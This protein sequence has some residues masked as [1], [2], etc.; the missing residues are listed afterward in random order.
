[1]R[2]PSSLLPLMFSFLFAVACADTATAPEGENSVVTVEDEPNDSSETG[3]DEDRTPTTREGSPCDTEG[4][5]DCDLD[6]A[7]VC[8]GGIWTFLES[9][10]GE[11]TCSMT[12]GTCEEKICDRGERRC[13]DRETIE[14][15]KPDQT[16][17][18]DP[19]AYPGTQICTDGACVGAQCFPGVMFLVDRSTSM[20]EH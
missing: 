15:C 12:T 8:Q 17:W 5:R 9:C 6:D 11:W 13:V 20:Q 19:Q 4:E 10:E 18:L 2:R 16:G 1:M 14:F 7:I 3:E